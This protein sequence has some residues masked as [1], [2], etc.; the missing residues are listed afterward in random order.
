MKKY[1]KNL[2]PLCFL[3]SLVV[4]GLIYSTLNNAD[5]RNI[6]ILVTDIDKAVPFIK[7]FVIPYCMWPVF[8][9][10]M[11]IY[12]CLKD[13]KTYYKT[14]ISIIFGEAVCFIIYYFFETMVPRPVVYGND[15]LSKLVKFVYGSDNPYN[16]FPSIHVL[17]TFIIMKGMLKCNVK[18]RIVNILGIIMGILIILSTQFIKQHVILDLLFAILM[19]D[20]IFNFIDYVESNKLL[21]RVSDSLKIKWGH[22]RI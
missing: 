3:I 21:Y 17:T 11:L 5:G 12:L 6:H 19:G 9:I 7:L 2:Y 10:G 1:K 20:G 13:V 4:L 15:I 18:S 16:C 22:E 14:L 8:I